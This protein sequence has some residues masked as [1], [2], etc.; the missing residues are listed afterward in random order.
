MTLSRAKQENTSLLSLGDFASDNLPDLVAIF[1]WLTGDE[2]PVLF[3]SRQL[4]FPKG[5]VPSIWTRFIHPFC[6][7][8]NLLFTITL[9]KFGYYIISVYNKDYLS[10][11]IE[12]AGKY[13]QFLGVEFRVDIEEA[14]LP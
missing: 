1:D 12:L 2:Q 13:R 14:I 10:V 6:Y 5:K 8:P 11:A 4:F 9:N 3:L 7:L